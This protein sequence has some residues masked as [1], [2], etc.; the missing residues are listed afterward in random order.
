MHIPSSLL[1]YMWT[2]TQSILFVSATY[3]VSFTVLPWSFQNMIIFHSVKTDLFPA[4]LS[5]IHDLIYF[6]FNRSVVHLVL[7][8]CWNCIWLEQLVGQHFTWRIIYFK[9]HPQRYENCVRAQFFHSSCRDAYLV[10][11]SGRRDVTA[12][13]MNKWCKGSIKSLS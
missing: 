7:S 2:I 11:V 1:V 13:D 9:H 3:K 4:L 8:F 5:L 10:K 6:A 12:S